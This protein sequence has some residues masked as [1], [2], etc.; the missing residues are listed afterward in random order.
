MTMINA[1]RSLLAVVLL[2]AGVPASNAVGGV[3]VAETTAKTRLDGLFA[4]LKGAA[5][6]AEL[7]RIEAEEEAQEEEA[8]QDP[9]EEKLNRINE[10]R[11]AMDFDAARRLLYE[12]LV[13]GSESQV[14]VA[15]N[16]LA[17][18]DE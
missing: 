15:K 5:T 6:E 13:E 14:A 9:V 12:V 11:D 1:T 17:Q 4:K 18:L 7:D 16:I 10:L 3:H 2:A 8:A